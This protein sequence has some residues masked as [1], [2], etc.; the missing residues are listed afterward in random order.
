MMRG[1]WIA[2]S[3]LGLTLA[4]AI[5]RP[6]CALAE[7][8]SA[9]HQLYAKR[10]AKSPAGVHRHDGLV[11]VVVEIPDARKKTEARVQLQCLLGTSRLIR[12]F[13]TPEEQ[14]YANVILRS[15]PF[16][17]DVCRELQPN[18]GTSDFELKNL[19][20]RVLENQ[21]VGEDY[22]YV[23]A[24][25]ES[26]LH[27][28]ANLGETSAPSIEA[29]LQCLRVQF[30]KLSEENPEKLVAIWLR[31]GAI[32]SALNV[33]NDECSIDFTL[34]ST[35]APK[36]DSLTMYERRT[37]ALSLL[38]DRNCRVGDVRRLLRDWPGFP[39]ALRWL[40]RYYADEQNY[41]AA[42]NTLLL[43][44]VDPSLETENGE[45]SRLVRAWHEAT[46]ESCLDEYAV[47]MEAFE[48]EDFAKQLTSKLRSLPTPAI[49]VLRTIGHFNF[50][51]GH[52]PGEPD[53]TDITRKPLSHS[54]NN[55]GVIQLLC[56][57]LQAHPADAEGWRAVGDAYSNNGHPLLAIATLTQAVRLQ[58][59]LAEAA[60]RLAEC[61]DQMGYH[62]LARGMSIAVLLSAN[63]SKHQVSASLDRL[64]GARQDK[65][66]SSQ[67]TVP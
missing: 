31:C 60:L 2:A 65:K 58:P 48:S 7:D 28:S 51:G 42:L 4:A 55:A 39:P 29:T 19:Q 44:R 50:P 17:L 62:E 33:A 22:R 52:V 38:Q 53:A 61:Y 43:S 5:S 66:A 20:T 67:S 16:L 11:F 6:S 56:K 8:L 35:G 59:N 15:F 36:L 63:P 40:R 64:S 47:M 18:F 23:T 30:S 54:S 34:S 26:D 32:E 13:V 12:Q 24:C 57:R 21:F 27:Q 37:T 14:Q 25:V 45:V 49:R 10:F 3:V 46:D 41:A 9:A 1:L